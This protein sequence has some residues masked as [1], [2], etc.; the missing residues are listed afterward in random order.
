[1]NIY[2]LTSVGNP[3]LELLL[4]PDC[5]CCSIQALDCLGVGSVCVCGGGGGGGGSLEKKSIYLTTCVHMC[6]YLQYAFYSKI[7]HIYTQTG[8]RTS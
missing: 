4:T 7:Y 5:S 8:A 6:I 2:T 1:M 3:F